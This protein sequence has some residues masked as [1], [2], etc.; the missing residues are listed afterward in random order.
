MISCSSSPA[1]PG[2][3]QLGKREKQKQE[4]EYKKERKKE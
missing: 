4:S 2:G 1:D 3:K